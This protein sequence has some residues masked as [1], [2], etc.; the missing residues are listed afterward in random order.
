MAWK[1]QYQ[2]KKNSGWG[3]LHKNAPIRKW[4]KP[5]K[6]IIHSKQEKMFQG[7]LRSPG[8]IIRYTSKYFR[9]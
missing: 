5:K 7:S 9:R 3:P 2:P 1:K 8:T 4:G 6:K